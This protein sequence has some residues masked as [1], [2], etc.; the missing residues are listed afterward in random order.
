MSDKK[1]I[2]IEN[3]IGPDY[4]YTDYIRTP[5]NISHAFVKTANLEED[6]GVSP[7]DQFFGARKGPCGSEDTV[8]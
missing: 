7:Y 1:G 8:T 3:V 5:Y 6:F 2:D 4:N